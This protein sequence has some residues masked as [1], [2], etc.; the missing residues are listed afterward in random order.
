[1][2]LSLSHS[3]VEDSPTLSAIWLVFA[4]VQIGQTVACRDLRMISIEDV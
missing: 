1:V 4:M 2:R 3:S